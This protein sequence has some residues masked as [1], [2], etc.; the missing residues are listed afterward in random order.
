MHLFLL[1][2]L[3]PMM[4]SAQHSEQP[5]KENLEDLRTTKDL[6]S[7]EDVKS[8]VVYTLERSP[9]LEHYLRRS[10]DE[11]DAV[12]KTDSRDAKKLDMDFAARF[13]RSQY[14]HPTTP[15]DCK[16]VFRLNMKGE[17]QN[18]CD[19]DDKKTQ[20]FRSFV[21]ELKKRF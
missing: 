20:E 8:E 17:E 16:V 14:E 18:I 1:I 15:G 12:K 21:E 6:F 3:L 2:L 11:D 10:K 4:A 5:A 7:I 9:Q 19:K 13:I